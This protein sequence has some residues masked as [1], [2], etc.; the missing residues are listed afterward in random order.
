MGAGTFVRVSDCSFWFH[1]ED[2]IMIFAIKKI[3]KKLRS[4]R[5]KFKIQIIIQKM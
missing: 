1:N 2:F 5:F 4:I 3:I